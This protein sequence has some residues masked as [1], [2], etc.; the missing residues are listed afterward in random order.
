MADFPIW[1]ELWQH[2]DAKKRRGCLQLAVRRQER[3][4][5]VLT[6]GLI[7][8][9]GY[10]L[11][12][13]EMVDGE[14]ICELQN[15][16]PRGAWAGRWGRHSPELVCRQGRRELEPSPDSCNPFWMS[17]QDF[18][19][20]FTEV[21][22]ARMVPTFWQSAVVTCSSER[23]SYPLISV[24]S[25]TQALFVLTQTDRRWARRP[26]YDN[27]IGLKVYRCRIVAPPQ[28]T[29]GVRQNVSSPFRN[30]ELLA[31]QPLSKAHSAVVEVARLEPNS[32]YIAAMESEYGCAYASLRVLTASAPRFRELSAPESSYFLQAQPDA[33]HAIDT[34]SFSSQG[35]MENN[36][37][38]ANVAAGRPNARMDPMKRGFDG[39]AQDGWRDWGNNDDDIVI[40]MPPFLQACMGTCDGEC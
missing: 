27:A 8:G 31:E 23:P 11:T 39:G 25:P 20:H 15:P 12:R 34:D 1:G 30:L 22:E 6:S 37:N 14:M 32:L 13:L 5:E 4:G 38:A 3:P 29:V 35:S 40:R 24:A 28:N 17:I 33:P 19:K 7:S 21:V 9:Y 18:C 26:E 16:W 36:S 10:P 2:L